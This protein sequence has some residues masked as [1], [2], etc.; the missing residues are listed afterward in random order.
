MTK[1]QALS[2]PYIRRA[3]SRDKDT[4][5]S[6]SRHTWYWGDYLLDA[7]EEWFHEQGSLMLVATIARVPVATGHM[8][9]PT[10]KEAWLEG[11]RVNP[12]YRHHGLA[13]R[14]THRFIIEARK[15][16][17][18]V[19]RL[20]TTSQTEAIL[21]V[22]THLKFKQVTDF[23]LL[24]KDLH[25]QQDK[26]RGLIKPYCPQIDSILSYLIRS[27]AMKAQHKL[28]SKGWRFLELCEEEIRGK[29]IRGEIR[30]ISDNHNIKSIVFV[31]SSPESL[32]ISFADGQLGTLKDLIYMVTTEALIYR[33]KRLTAKIPNLGYIL[34]VFKETGFQPVDDL[35]FL[36]YEKRF[37]H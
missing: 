26:K 17:V 15:R 16:G 2:R 30:A 10:P 29:S 36:I 9:F 27:S 14:I 28:V 7:W 18:K 4:I 34:D 13:N 33:K 31:E 24:Q 23:K 8:S 21:R 37:K 1:F 35:T 12:K 22:M 25:I 19:L 5:F 32:D 3:L 11:L 20:A 6:F